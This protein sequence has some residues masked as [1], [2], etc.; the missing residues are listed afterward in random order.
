MRDLLH[1]IVNVFLKPLY[2]YK[3]IEREKS[4]RESENERGGANNL[5]TL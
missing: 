1:K 2:I 4:E 5:L 3:E